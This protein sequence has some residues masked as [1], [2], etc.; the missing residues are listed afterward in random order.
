MREVAITSA[1]A[2]QMVEATAVDSPFNAYIRAHCLYS[3]TLTAE[4]VAQIG[5]RLAIGIELFENELGTV[6]DG[7][8][9]FDET[10]GGS[11]AYFD[12]NSGKIFLKLATTFNSIDSMMNTGSRFRKPGA[13]FTVGGLDSAALLYPEENHHWLLRS[14]GLAQEG[15]DAWCQ[16]SDAQQASVGYKELPFEQIATVFLEL[17]ASGNEMDIAYDV[18]LAPG[19]QMRRF[20]DIVDT[21]KDYHPVFT[22]ISGDDF[23]ARLAGQIG[24]ERET[25]ARFFD[26]RDHAL[27]CCGRA[28]SQERRWIYGSDPEEEGLYYNREENTIFIGLGY[29]R[30]YA[31]AITTAGSWTDRTGNRENPDQAVMLDMVSAVFDM[32]QHTVL[33]RPEVSVYT[34]EE[35]E[36]GQVSERAAYDRDQVRQSATRLLRLNEPLQI[37]A[38][39][40]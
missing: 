22:S 4:R 20:E 9:D 35:L 31:E 15:F 16:A 34:P 12:P 3:P 10:V 21:S 28:F 17:L 27:D 7:I 37:M 14:L 33:T 25:V 30:R 11:R 6:P 5:K 29:I 36:P 32:Y 1:H 39:A 40:A 23:A 19:E 18:P 8:Y 13:R 26:L 2:R 24:H 38:F